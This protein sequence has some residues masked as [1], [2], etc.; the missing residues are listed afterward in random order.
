MSGLQIHMSSN[1]SPI[2]DKDIDRIIVALQDRMQ[3]LNEEKV[4]RRK[5]AASF[6]GLHE[7]TL[8][9]LSNSGSIPYHRLDGLSDK[10]YLRSELIHLI[11]KS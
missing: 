7:R 5:D 10:L 4:M 11:K 2:P 1:D 3:H 8:D 6:L 9:R